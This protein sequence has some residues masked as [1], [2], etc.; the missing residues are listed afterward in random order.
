M[1]LAADT[2][3]G[4]TQSFLRS[5]MELVN[6]G[7]AVRVTLATGTVAAGPFNE[8][9]TMKWSV[10]SAVRDTMNSPFCINCTVFESVFPWVDPNGG[11]TVDDEDREF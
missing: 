8:V 3:V 9:G 11:G 5:P 1:D 10:T 2:Y 7:T 6:G 4:A